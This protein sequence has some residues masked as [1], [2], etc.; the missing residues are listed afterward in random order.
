M[1]NHYNFLGN[2]DDDWYIEQN[3][4]FYRDDSPAPPASPNLYAT[5]YI[6]TEQV[7]HLESVDLLSP[8]VTW[9]AKVSH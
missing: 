7:F 2:D 8:D 4:G 1:R 9:K 5:G 6:L 3:V